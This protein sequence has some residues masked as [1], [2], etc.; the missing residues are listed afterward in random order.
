MSKTAD[1]EVVSSNPTD[2]GWPRAFVPTSDL[3]N[4]VYETAGLEVPKI[5]PVP[6]TNSTTY[7]FITCRNEMNLIHEERI[8][9]TCGMPLVE[10][11][12]LAP[13]TYSDMRVNGGGL[14]PRCM[15]LALQFCPHFPREEGAIVAYAYHGPGTIYEWDHEPDPDMF[16]MTLPIR[17]GAIGLTRDEVKAIAAVDPEGLHPHIWPHAPAEHPSSAP[18]TTLQT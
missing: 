14:H 9:Q 2:A 5:L 18:M 10:S 1:A 6:W 7:D 8:C 16:N 11:C 15:A 4:L 12:G 13:R 17:Q 3:Y